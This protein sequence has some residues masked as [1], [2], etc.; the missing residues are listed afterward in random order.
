MSEAKE[1]PG[2]AEQE[3]ALAQAKQA[4]AVG[5]RVLEEL[6][7]SKQ[8]GGEI[9]LPL[10]LDVPVAVT[11]EVGRR[12]MS[13][14][15]LCRL[16]PGSLLELDREAHEPADVLVNGKVVARGEIVTIDERYGV[17]ISQ[18]FKGTEG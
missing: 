6:S 11:V 16:A 18:V 13:L 7:R 5:T 12:V 1:K 10:L 14:G 2:A 4:V 9:G 8:D 17:R 3:Q 15:E